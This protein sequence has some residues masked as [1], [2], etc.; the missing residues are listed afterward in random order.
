M[1][2][3]EGKKI[4]GISSFSI[5]PDRF[6]WLELTAKRNGVSNSELIRYLIDLAKA[7]PDF[8]VPAEPFFKE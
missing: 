1:K 2:K 3:P 5:D 4:M 6:D 8:E 7:D